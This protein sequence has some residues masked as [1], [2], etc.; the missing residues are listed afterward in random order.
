M[1]LEAGQ[2]D[3]W[4]RSSLML[5]PSFRG[6]YRTPVLSVR[7]GIISCPTVIPVIKLLTLAP[8]KYPS[9]SLTFNMLHWGPASRVSQVFN[10]ALTWVLSMQ[11]R[12]ARAADLRFF[13]LKTCLILLKRN[14]SDIIVLRKTR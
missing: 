2:L 13:I 1:E 5:I 7:L 12:A 14:R 9:G 10:C 4:G 11:M 6:M 8:W 3:W